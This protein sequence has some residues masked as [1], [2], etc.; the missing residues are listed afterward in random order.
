M[1]TTAR[2]IT[3]A[4]SWQAWGLVTMTLIGWLM[5]GSVQQGGAL[6]LTLALVGLVSYIL[7]ERL[8]ARVRWGRTNGAGGFTIPS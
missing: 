5:T 4:I 7:H 8:W 3:K 1:D 6:A 2:T